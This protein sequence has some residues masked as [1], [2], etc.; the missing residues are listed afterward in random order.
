MNQKC[1]VEL[2]APTRSGL[3][4]HLS[5]VDVD[6]EPRYSRSGQCL[7]DYLVL[8]IIGLFFWL[9]TDIWLMQIV[10]VVST[11]VSGFV[12]RKSRNQYGV[13]N[14]KQGF[15][16]LPPQLHNWA[17]RQ[18]SREERAL[19]CAMNLWPKVDFI[20]HRKNFLFK[21]QFWH[22]PATIMIRTKNIA[23]NAAESIR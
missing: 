21:R 9:N 10:M 15:S 2:E 5:F 16:L 20:Q 6:L 19:N 12:A 22:L 23:Q 14:P 4:L 17:T 11:Q 7:R 13:C 1:A 8:T 18:I 3:V